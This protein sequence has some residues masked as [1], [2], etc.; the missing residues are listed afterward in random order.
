MKR[1]SIIP[2][3]MSLTS[4]LLYVA[5]IVTFASGDN[6]GTGAVFMSIASLFLVIAISRSRAE[7]AA[8]QEQDRQDGDD[9]D[10]AE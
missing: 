6:N 7:R 10:K 9:N 4:A 3:V 5:S 8:L 1:K 2:I